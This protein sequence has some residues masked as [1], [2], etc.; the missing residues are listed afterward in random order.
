LPD[1]VDYIDSWINENVEICYQLM[2]SESLEKIHEWIQNW[3]D[4]ADFE[5]VPIINS[6]EAK[7]KVLSRS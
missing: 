3:N 6:T 1:G 4:L 7:N 5:V 2:E